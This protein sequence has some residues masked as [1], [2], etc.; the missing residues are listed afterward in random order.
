ML[1]AKERAAGSL[2][3]LNRMSYILGIAAAE[4]ASKRGRSWTVS[5]AK[6]HEVF[7]KPYMSKAGISGIADAEI[8]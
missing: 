5:V 8:A 4:I 1:N 6:A 2:N 7:A 3:G